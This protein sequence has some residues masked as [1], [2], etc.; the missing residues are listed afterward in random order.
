MTGFIEPLEDPFEM[1]LFLKRR[2]TRPIFYDDVQCEGGFFYMTVQ[3]ASQL[4][5]VK[6][7]SGIRFHGQKV[8]KAE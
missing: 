8:C 6:Q 5:A 7:L 3:G 2:A 4:N 1:A